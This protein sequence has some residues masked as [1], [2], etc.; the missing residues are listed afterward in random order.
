MISIRIGFEKSI[1]LI[2]IKSNIKKSFF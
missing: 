1:P 2:F